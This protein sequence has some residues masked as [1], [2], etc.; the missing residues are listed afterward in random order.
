MPTPQTPYI[1]SGTIY[2]SRGTVGNTVVRVGELTTTTNAQGQYIVDLADFADGYTDGTSYNII[3]FDEHDNE[4]KADTITVS[5]QGLTKNLFL[6]ARNELN[7]QTRNSDTRRIEARTVGNKPV[8]HANP[9]HIHNFER[10]LTQLMANN[11]SGQPDYIG[12][13]PP[14]TPSSEAKWLIIKMEYD[15]GSAKPPTARKYASGNAEFDKEW[16]ER[17][18]YTYS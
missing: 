7:A 18:V 14:G 9:M 3:S 11:S 13:A 1:V 17:A 2:T 12:Y 4:Y 5:G 15:N 6:D 10:P 16:D 8:T